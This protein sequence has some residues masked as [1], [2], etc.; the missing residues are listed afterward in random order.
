MPMGKIYYSIRYCFLFLGLLISYE[1]FGQSLACNNGVNISMDQNC[2][3]TMD[4]SH[5]L[6][7]ADALANPRNYLLSV[8]TLDGAVPQDVLVYDAS[9]SSFSDSIGPQGEFLLFSHPGEYI[10]T[11]VRKS[12]GLQCW[13]DLRVEDKLPPF[14]DDCPCAAA[15]PPSAECFFKCAAIPTI[16]NSDIVTGDAGL[17]PVFRDNCG[18]ITDVSFR[19]ELTQDTACGEWIITRTWTAL[20]PDGSGAMVPRDLNCVQRFFFE[21]L[22]VDAIIPPS[23]IVTVTCGIDTDPESLRNYFSDTTFFPNPNLDTA[24]VRSYPTLPDTIPGHG[25]VLSRIGQGLVPNS[26]DNYCQVTASYSDSPIIP[27]CGDLGY[28]FVRT[29]HI[30]DWCKNETIPALTQIIKVMDQE[31]PSFTISDTLAMSSTSTHS[32]NTDIIVPAP[33]T[34][35]DNCADISDLTWIAY[36]E[37]GDD[38]FEANASNGF[39]LNDVPAGTHVV[40]Y[41]VSDP[42]GNM[43]ID[44][45]ILVLKDLVK[46][47][48][49]TKRSLKIT[50]A[51]FQGECTAKVF[52]RNINAGSFDA[53]DTNLE[54]GIRRFGTDDP[55]TDFVKF[56][57]ADLTEITTTG[58]P[59]G[60]VIIELQVMDDCGNTNLGWTTVLLEDRQ[61]DVTTSC[62]SSSIILDCT[63]SLEDAIETYAPTVLLS[64]CT[65]RNLPVVGVIRSSTITSRCNTGVAIVDYLIQG[66]NDIVCTKTFTL[67]DPDDVTIIWPSAVITVSCTD[68]DFG[69]PVIS[70]GQC[71]DL[72][73]TDEI[74][75]YDVPPGLGYCRKLVRTISVIDWCSY[76]PNSGS[77]VGIY[78][79]IQTIKVRD[80]DRPVIE[81]SDAV[82]AADAN[83]AA[84][85]ITLQARGSD[86]GICD[87][88]LIWQAAIDADGDGVFEIELDVTGDSIATA[89]VPVAIPV[90][91]HD[92]R[93]RALDDCGNSDEVVCLLTVRDDKAP[94]PQCIGAVSTATMSTDGSVTIWAADF[95]PTGKSFD[96]CDSQ[97]RYSFSPTN[98][99]MTNMRF[100]CADLSDGVSELVNLRVYVFDSQGNSDFCSVVLRIDDNN[101]VCTDQGTTVSSFISGTITTPSGDRL[102]SARVS[103][104]SMTQNLMVEEMTDVE[105]TYAFDDNALMSDYQISVSKSG[106]DLNGVSTLDLIL[107]Q[108]HILGLSELDGPYN[109]I[110][111]DVTR[112]A[113]ISAVDLVQIRNLI[114]GRTESFVHGHSWTFVAADQSFADATSPWP[115]VEVIDLDQLTSDMADQDFIGIK[116]GDVNGNAIANSGF[117]ADN[118]SVEITS[119]IVENRAFGKGETVGFNIPLKQYQNLRGLQLGVEV[120]GTWLPEL[121]I[122]GELLSEDQY[123]IDGDQLVVSLSSLDKSLDGSS[124]YLS[125]ESS[126]SGSISDAVRL[127]DKFDSE[128][129]EGDD[130]SQAQVQLQFTSLTDDDLVLYQNTPNPFSDETSI[131]FKIS[132]EGKVDLTV[133]DL[134]GRQLF[135][136]SGQYNAGTHTIALSQEMLDKEGVL[137][138]QVSFENKLITKKMISFK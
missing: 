87:N 65:N 32:C 20:V 134:T 51:S 54:M 35:Y 36:I 27:H 94:S 53:C 73:I 69:E 38:R 47:V 77:D 110:A 50:F 128:I 15:S 19:D 122:N 22:G 92:V 89:L 48:A 60:E 4:A 37:I 112:D 107:I 42:C 95:D 97:L 13:G 59:S 133:F 118:R 85:G 78:R 44:S 135:G 71:N 105:G 41:K 119:L 137:Y 124:L 72:N 127:M 115:L 79:F 24:L 31:D 81:C 57:G 68:S 26:V 56:D 1:S 132:K 45:T 99:T 63:D 106:D 126:Q 12:D 28:K 136:S 29:W 8:K 67:G 108:R 25:I 100:T 16:K 103:N 10:V 23:D 114:L 93:W 116:L 86:T 75:S 117:A 129:Y 14:T 21:A 39:L 91:L 33:D 52:T 43:A 111:A 121:S 104:Q 82:F 64:G 90:G 11:V 58:T 55:F 7:G 76:M 30:I 84:S 3:V 2:E 88:G 120:K 6:K 61:T 102:E 49:I 80:E 62:G 46:P 98:P 9:T 113:R 96:D 125:F 66:S 18:V 130:L 5:I 83:C 70:G 131:S 101:N 74:E 17:N 40:I 138:Y 109:L 123:V 34:L